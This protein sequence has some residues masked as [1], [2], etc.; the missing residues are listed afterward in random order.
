MRAR[1]GTDNTAQARRTARSPHAAL[2]Q[3]SP[4][5][6]PVP[7]KLG[8]ARYTGRLRGSGGRRLLGSAPPARPAPQVKLDENDAEAATLERIAL[9]AQANQHPPG[10]KAMLLRYLKGEY[11]GSTW[12][13]GCED[14][15]NYVEGRMLLYDDAAVEFTCRRVLQD[16]KQFDT[17]ALGNNAVTVEGLAHVIALFEANSSFTTLDVSGNQVFVG[18]LWARGAV[19]EAAVTPEGAV[20][21]ESGTGLCCAESACRWAPRWSTGWAGGVRDGNFS[22][23]DISRFKFVQNCPHNFQAAVRN[24]YVSRLSEIARRSTA[25]AKHRSAFVDWGWSNSVGTRP[26]AV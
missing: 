10:L 19:F 23:W 12:N 24:T 5:R 6:G 26:L 1:T 14:P 11:P 3:A 18:C 16:S 13:M 25:A 15:L 17:L 22:L 21:T 4:V 2:P 20:S 8:P 9:L 7:T